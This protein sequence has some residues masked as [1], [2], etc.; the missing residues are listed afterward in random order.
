MNI[1]ETLKERETTHG[2]WANGCEVAQGIKRV[3]DK[4]SPIYP[5]PDV[6]KEGL[7]RIRM[8]L[9]RIAVGH[10]SNPEH[11]HDIAGYAT[12][13]EKELRLQQMTSTPVPPAQAGLTPLK[14]L[15]DQYENSKL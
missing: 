12:L 14:D 15:K 6:V 1:E 5:R 2:S 10:H 3:L 13:V 4:F 8:K 9:S 11:W 7:D